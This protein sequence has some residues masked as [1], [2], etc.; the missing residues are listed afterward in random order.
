MNKKDLTNLV[1]ECF[2]ELTTEGKAALITEKFAS[3]NV[4]MIKNRLKGR[5]KDV[6]QMLHNAHGIAWDQVP[7]SFTKKG[8][9]TSKGM[10]FFFINK[11]KDN[12]YS[13]DSWDQR[14]FGPNLLGVTIGKKIVY[15]SRES[16]STTKSTSFRRSNDAMG[17]RAKEM[18]N[19]KRFNSIADE[20]W[21]VDYIGAAKD[22]GTN[23][24][25]GERSEAKAGATALISAKKV[26]EDNQK[27]YEEL[28]NQRLGDSDPGKQVAKM[29]DAVVKEY[30][31]SIE[32]KVSMLKKGKVGRGWDGYL[33]IVTSA[34]TNIIRSFEYFIQAENSIVKGKERD[35]KDGNTGRFSEEDYYRKDMIKNAREIQVSYKKFKLA[36]KKV[37]MDKSFYDMRA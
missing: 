24:K 36:L 14:I 28:I 11:A 9:D 4:A 15:V 23:R 12:P 37:D 26:K 30:G 16:Y 29:V 17:T 2:I 32:L 31:K 20:V 7:D 6:F 1:K 25:T 22:H 21:N 10:N 35:S 8:L 19:F 34:Y 27:R 33:D 3:K 18:N 5:D 13:K